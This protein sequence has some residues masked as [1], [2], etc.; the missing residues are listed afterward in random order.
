MSTTATVNNVLEIIGQLNIEEQSM[1]AEIVA[2]RV[3]EE[4]RKELKRSVDISR[5]EYRNGKTESGSV[6]DFLK[7][8]DAE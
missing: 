7:A 8:I 5:K 6:D 3:R 4:R 1:I 2:N